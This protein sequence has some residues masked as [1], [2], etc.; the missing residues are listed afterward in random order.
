[1]HLYDLP[2]IRLYRGETLERN[3]PWIKNQKKNA[4]IVR[5]LLNLKKMEKTM[6]TGIMI[7]GYVQTK[8]AIKLY[9]HFILNMHKKL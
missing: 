2:L 8:N 9:F 3:I 4:L 7:Y 6:E 5:M 1:M